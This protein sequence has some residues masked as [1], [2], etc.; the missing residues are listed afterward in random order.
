MDSLFYSFKI[1]NY[2]AQVCDCSFGIICKGDLK[3]I[4][5]YEYIS[6]SQFCWCSYKKRNIN[7]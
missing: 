7:W 2:M 6:L 5:N 1:Y 3:A 4:K